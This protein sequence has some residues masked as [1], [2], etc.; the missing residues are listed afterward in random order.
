MRPALLCGV[1]V[2]LIC[3]VGLAGEGWSEFRGPG[4][5]RHAPR[6]RHLPGE[7]STTQ[8]VTW[9]VD[10]PG[11]GWSSPAVVDG[12]IYLTTAVPDGDGLEAEQSLR[13]LCL[14]AATGKTLWNVEVFRQP[15]DK[16]HKKNSHAS[17]T[18]IVDGGQ[19]F[20]HFGTHG[21]ASL[22][23]DGQIL[24]MNR[25]LTYVPTH[26]NGGSPALVGD[27]LVLCC[28][29]ADIQFVVALDRRTGKIVW[30]TDRPE[31]AGGPGFSFSTPLAIEIGG[32]TQVI[33]P[34]SNVVIAYNPADGTEIWQVRY[35]GYSVIP[36]PVYG[37]GL[38]FVCTGYNTPT[39]LAI[40]PDGA[41]DV[42]ETHVE[43]QTNRNAPHTPSPLLVGEA[44]Y[45]VSDRGVARCVDAKTGELHWEK[46]LGGNYS[47]SPVYADGRIYLLSEQ[48]EAIVLA[49][50]IEYHELARNAMDARTLASYAVDGSALFLRTDTQLYRIEAK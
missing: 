24:W 27:R 34:G 11:L 3:G 28:D 31:D 29:G 45:F 35:K 18:A 2:V 21:T 16:V 5:Q 19:V 1:G 20:V 8:N 47:A 33:C 42:T 40:R 17:P 22:S 13:A 32:K 38:V 7:W 4:G 36:R 49:P 23:L 41:G 15:Q 48:G 50:G 25:E 43:W 30:K 26:G 39:L 10:V 12:R 6:A 44:L 9:A 14:E 37:H 46:R